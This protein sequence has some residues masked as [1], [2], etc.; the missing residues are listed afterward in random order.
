M[1]ETISRYSQ[2]EQVGELVAA[3]AK[4]KLKYGEVTKSKVNKYTG[5]LYADLQ[6]LMTAA[7]RPLAEENI[8]VVHFPIE[9][10]DQKKAGALTKIVH[11]SGQFFANE[12][13]MPATG[14]AM[15]GVEKLDAQTV[16]GGVTYAKRCNYGAL[17]GL[18]GEDDDD[19]NTLADKSTDPVQAPKPK[20]V[21]APEV[22]RAPAKQDNAATRPNEVKVTNVPALPHKPV[23]ITSAGTETN[24]TFSSADTGVPKAV[25]PPE[26]PVAQSQDEKIK[27]RFGI[28]DDP[29]IS[30]PNQS[31]SAVA[32]ISSPSEQVGGLGVKPSKTEF[33]A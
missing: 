14:K 22:N 13:L 8:V 12:F 4:A 7:E 17:A 25:I 26:A 16:T 19:G 1:S 20:Q 18:V 28:E 3:L 11:A 6:D 9:N 5:S 21:R 29:Q 30:S 32:E 23:I 31:V 15:G 2:S 24:Q 27:M 33:D 10:I